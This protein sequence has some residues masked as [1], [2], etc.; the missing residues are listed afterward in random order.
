MNIKNK[1]GFTLLEIIIVIIIVGVLA[2]LAL[3]RFFSTIEFARS[4]EASNAL[5]VIRNSVKRCGMIDNDVSNCGTFDDIDIDDPGSDAAAHFTY[6]IVIT[7]AT[8][9]SIIAERNTTDGGTQG[10]TVVLSDS[11]SGAVR[12]GTGAF[13]SIK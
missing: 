7:D 1:S 9:F 13:S 6:E 5:G 12:S 11:P 10:D 4:T 3:P 2:S 8:T